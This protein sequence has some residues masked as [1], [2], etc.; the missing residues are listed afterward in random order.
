MTDAEIDKIIDRAIEKSEKRSDARMRRYIGAISEQSQHR[1]EAIAEQYLGLSKK[2][3]SVIQTVD[4][5]NTKV[6]SL[7]S[8]VVNVEE[9]LE[10]VSNT[11]NAT[12]EEVGAIRMEMTENNQRITTLEQKV[13]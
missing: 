2:L 5:T 7:T 8:R 4:E 6:D 9:I 13:R 1:I 11:T 3:D 12:F 10:E